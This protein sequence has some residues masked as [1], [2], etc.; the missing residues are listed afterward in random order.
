MPWLYFIIRVVEE[1]RS[2]YPRSHLFCSFQL[3][4]EQ[5]KDCILEFRIPSS[6][7]GLRNQRLLGPKIWSIKQSG[8]GTTKLFILERLS[9]T[10]GSIQEWTSGLPDWSRITPKIAGFLDCSTTLFRKIRKTTHWFT[11]SR[12]S[13][14]WPGITATLLQTTRIANSLR[15]FSSFKFEG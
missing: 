9:E 4:V 8:S 7:L 15:F 12:R 14:F 6:L 2:P 1:S 5:L 10:S 11:K 13:T 3:S